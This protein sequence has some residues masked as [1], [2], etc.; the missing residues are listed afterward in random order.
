MPEGTK[1]TQSSHGS[2]QT[3]NKVPSKQ[4][5]FT[6]D[7]CCHEGIWPFMISLLLVM[8]VVDELCMV[9]LTMVKL[10]TVVIQIKFLYL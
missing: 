1:P 7:H 5:T 2:W 3:R 6:K 9:E 4:S 10:Q 8:A